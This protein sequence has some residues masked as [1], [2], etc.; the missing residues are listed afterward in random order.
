V[1]PTVEIALTWAPSST[2]VS[3]S[4]MTVAGWPTLTLL[5]S[6]SLRA[7]VIVIE[8]VLT[9]SAN[10]DVELPEVEED[11]EL[12]PPRLPAVVPAVPAPPPVE[13]LDDD[14]LLDVVDVEALEVDP[15]DTESPGVRFASDTIV[16]L[17]G[18]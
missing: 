1:V 14:P 3:A 5:M 12:E 8:L 13:E 7:T 6:D 10:G 9:I 17:I 15:A 4:S 16:P 11:D 18:A 2:P